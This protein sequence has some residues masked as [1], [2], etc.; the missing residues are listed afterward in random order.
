MKIANIHKNLLLTVDELIGDFSNALTVEINKERQLDSY[1][2]LTSENRLRKNIKQIA[3]VKYDRITLEI[4]KAVK[5][6]EKVYGDMDY[7]RA[8]VVN[9]EKAIGESIALQ[10]N[11]MTNSVVT[12]LRVDQIAIRRS[13]R[14]NKTSMKGALV[15]ARSSGVIVPL[16]IFRD[17]SGRKWES[18][19]YFK[20]LT[21]V[22]VYNTAREI[23]VDHALKAG[24]TEIEI[25]DE[26]LMLLDDYEELKPRLFHPN[27][28]RLFR[29][30]EE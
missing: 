5:K 24:H 17:K 29:L 30:V 3:Q 11:R 2:Y 18:L 19:T 15:K 10:F 28:K 1:L 9:I 25:I 14:K 22:I 8:S 12:I 21:N 16:Y 20:M 23:V 4:E 7:D 26:G 6:V 13:A 27:S